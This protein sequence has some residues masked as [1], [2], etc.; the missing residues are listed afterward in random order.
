MAQYSYGLHPVKKMLQFSSED[1]EQLLCLKSQ[2]QRLQDVI[3]LAKEKRLAV[4]FCSKQELSDL[5]G[6]E[7]HQG[8][9]L[10]VREGHKAAVSLDQILQQVTD[11]SLFL[12]L[13]GVQDPHN[14][15]ACLRSADGAGVKAVI[16]PKDRAAG[17]TPVVQKVA[18]GAAE[19]V[20]LIT[21][22]NL[23]RSLKALKDAG[24]WLVG[25]SGDADQTLYQLT[26]KGP[27]AVVMGAEGEGMRRLTAE[28]C[29][30]LVKLPMNGRV[31]SL[32]VSVASG[33]CLYEVLRQRMSL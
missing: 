14:L 8:C 23:A 32:N 21:V 27:I 4:V 18:A 19:S 25:T 10:K 20:P 13:D 11:D 15:G 6:S 16:V 17:M 31:E 2:N 1:C 26:L 29:D 3:S 24:V 12:V 30:Y 28:Q 7:K 9:V 5:A 33:I 22:T